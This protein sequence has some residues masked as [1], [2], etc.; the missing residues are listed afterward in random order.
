MRDEAQRLP[1]TQAADRFNELQLE[2]AERL[3][4][5][6]EKLVRY[7]RQQESAVAGIAIDNIREAKLRELVE[8]RA[9][10]FSVLDR[11][12]TLVPEPILVAAAVL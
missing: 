12:S 9:A 4:G 3:A 11:R 5:E 7:Y 6:R 2:H 10:D 8:H 1:E